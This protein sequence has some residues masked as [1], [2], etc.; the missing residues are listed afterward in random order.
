MVLQLLIIHITLCLLDEISSRV[1]FYINLGSN[2]LILIYNPFHIPCKNYC[3]FYLILRNQDNTRCHP[4]LGIL[5]QSFYVWLQALVLWL[6]LQ[7]PSH[8]MEPM[9]LP[10]VPHQLH[11]SYFAVP[12]TLFFFH[13]FTASLTIFGS[14]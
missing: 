12:E 8:L 6:A 4:P 14:K 7:S 2:S 3:L 5:L 13:H 10:F 9:I 1:H 11:I